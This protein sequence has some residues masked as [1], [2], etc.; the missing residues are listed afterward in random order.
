MEVCQQPAGMLSETRKIRGKQRKPGERHLEAQRLPQSLRGFRLPTP[1]PFI[2]LFVGHTDA[3]GRLKLP[4]NCVPLLLR[5]GAQKRKKKRPSLSHLRYSEKRRE[6]DEEKRTEAAGHQ[7]EAASVFCHSSGRP[8]SRIEDEET[9]T[10]TAISP[11]FAR[12]GHGWVGV[13]R[14]WE[15]GWICFSQSASVSGQRE[16]EGR[17]QGAA[18][19]HTASAVERVNMCPAGPVNP[20]LIGL[21]PAYTRCPPDSM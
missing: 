10:L 14:S 4:E 8:R 12:V 21:Q 16:R 1:A 19:H 18:G 13:R 20:F 3:S 2:F 11:A 9:V 17:K 15:W 6:R 5:R 7:R